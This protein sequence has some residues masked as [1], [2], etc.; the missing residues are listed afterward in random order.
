VHEVEQVVEPAARIGRR[1]TVKLG[2]HFRYPP[3]RPIGTSVG[4]APPFGGASFGI[5][6]SVPSRNCCRPSPC[7]RAFPGSEYYSGSVPSRPGRSTMDPA[8]PSTPEAWDRARA[9]TVPVFTDDSLNEGG[10]QLC[11]CGIATATPQHFTMASKT[12]N[13]MPAP[14]FPD[15]VARDECAPHPAQIR[16][17]RAGRALRDVQRRFLAYSSPSRSPD[18][19]HLAVLARPGLVRAAPTLPAP[20]GTGCPQLQH[21][22]ATGRR[23]RPSTSTQTVSA[24]RRTQFMPKSMPTASC[25]AAVPS[26]ASHKAPRADAGQTARPRWP[27][28][29]RWPRLEAGQMPSEVSRHDA[30]HKQSTDLDSRDRARSN[31]RPRHRAARVVRRRRQRRRRRKRLLNRRP[32]SPP[33]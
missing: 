3:A 33:V 24:S 9:E 16:Q 20:P 11:P 5:T 31:H 18:P 21:P 27:P 23:C 2:L 12:D 29:S 30:D 7:A 28:Y 13:H 4:G 25:L 8:R 17:I 1:P 10:A 22:A 15:A 26:A 19:H 32:T 6:A 14:E